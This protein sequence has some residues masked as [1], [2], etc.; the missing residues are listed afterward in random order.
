MFESDTTLLTKELRN[1]ILSENEELVLKALLD[2]VKY[3][4]LFNPV[5]E[6][7]KTDFSEFTW[8]Q[9]LDT[10]HRYLNNIKNNNLILLEEKEDHYIV[11]IAPYFKKVPEL[12][13]ME[14]QRMGDKY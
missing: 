2:K 3:R 9:K 13:E 10:F 4:G 12:R 6:I 14:K 1:K 5:I 7:S 8:V 11:N